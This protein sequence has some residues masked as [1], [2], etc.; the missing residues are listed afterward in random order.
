MPF[1]IDLKEVYPVHLLLN[2]ERPYLNQRWYSCSAWEIIG[3]GDGRFRVADLIHASLVIPIQ[4]AWYNPLVI[5]SENAGLSGQ[6]RGLK[7]K[8][9]SKCL[10]Q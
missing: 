8:D 5:T 4:A 9:H 10:W 3:I 6:A 1:A 2:W 7:A